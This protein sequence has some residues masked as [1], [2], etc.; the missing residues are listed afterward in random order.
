[1]TL[2]NENVIS[3]F[4]TINSFDSDTFVKQDVVANVDA[5]SSTVSRILNDFERAK[6]VSVVRLVG[7]INCYRV[8]RSSHLYAA[9][10]HF[11]EVLDNVSD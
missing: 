11:V 1:M 10:R 8:N 4:R 9:L 7:R 6:L 2:F 3:V 5:A